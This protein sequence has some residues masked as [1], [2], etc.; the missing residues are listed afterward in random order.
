MAD[1]TIDIL[2]PDL[3]AQAVPHER[4]ARLRREAPVYWHAEP[5]GRGFW[6]ITKHADVV[7]VLKDAATFSNEAGG[8]SIPDLPKEDIRRSPDNLAIMD[9]PRHTL[10]RTLIGQ[11]FTSAGL[12][13]SEEFIRQRVAELTTEVMEKGRF[14]FV[15]DFAARLPMAVILKLVGVPSGDE[16]QL[17]DWILSLLATDDPQYAK[18]EA[19]RMAIGKSF[20]EYAH[21]LAAERR[22][23]PRDDLL[24]LL[25]A[26]EVE[27]KKLSYHE[28]AMLFMLLLAAGNDTPRLLL[29][30]AM[31]SLIEHPDQCAMLRQDP[32]LV[33]GL[34]EEVLRY[35]PPFAHFRRTA[36]RDCEMRG[37]RIA[38]GDKV[39]VWHVSANRDE[40]VFER[41][42]EFDMARRPNDH[43]SFGHGPHFCLGNALARM[44]ARVALSE[45]LRR[46][47]SLELDGPPERV[48][49]NWF[50][51]FKKMNVIVGG[52]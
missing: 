51:G 22:S 48:R 6:A 33:G 9:P 3:Y 15:G 4:F 30:S 11:S 27:G 14:D 26:A 37:Q 52:S 17:N 49:S 36:T 31:Y 34:I 5:G 2:D 28:F 41:P 50:N 45:C 21:A 8:V 12:A 18:T 38:A 29:A 46:M 42:N 10:Y 40:E 1:P 39:V 44:S 16:A 19:E 43:V 35:Y 20:M 23:S 32:S 7:Q 47:G 25:M 24:S 13:R